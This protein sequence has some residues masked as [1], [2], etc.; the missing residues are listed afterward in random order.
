MDVENVPLEIKGD[1]THP[2]F[3]IVPN[4]RQQALDSMVYSSDFLRQTRT[5]FLEWNPYGLIVRRKP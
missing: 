2:N 3:C 1:Q 5:H 4:E